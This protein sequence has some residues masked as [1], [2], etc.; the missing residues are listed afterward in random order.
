[1]TE[2]SDKITSLRTFSSACEV[3]SMLIIFTATASSVSLLT[4]NLTLEQN[5]FTRETH[6]LTI[7]FLIKVCTSLLN[8]KE[9]DYMS[10][11]TRK[12]QS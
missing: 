11:L 9:T 1:M 6:M 5:I 4:A 7:K 8:L 3:R 10:F 12:Q 2:T